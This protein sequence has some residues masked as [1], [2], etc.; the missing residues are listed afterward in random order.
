MVHTE[1]SQMQQTCLE[2]TALIL[3]SP[4]YLLTVLSQLQRRHCFSLLS[5]PTV[6]CP[7]SLPIPCSALTPLCYAHLLSPKSNRISTSQNQ[8]LKDIP[9]P[10]RFSP[11]VQ[12]AQHPSHISNISGKTLTFEQER[13]RGR[14]QDEF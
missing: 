11:S 1:S 2:K 13:K 14:S 3:P 6:P 9:K 10:D 8:E 4:T 12:D 7:C 5:S